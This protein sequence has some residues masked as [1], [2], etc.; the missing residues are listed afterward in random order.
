VQC[1]VSAWRWSHQD[2]ILHALPLHHV[3]GIINALYCAHAVGATVNFLPKFSPAAVWQQLMVSEVE[4]VIG[5]CHSVLKPSSSQRYACG[6]SQH[7]R[8]CCSSLRK[9]SAGCA[10]QPQHFSRSIADT[11]APLPF[12]FTCIRVCR[13]AM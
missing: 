11:T 5:L 3:H 12:L 9:P 7:T 10:L 2:T 4:A 13:L 1:L 8:G 6:G